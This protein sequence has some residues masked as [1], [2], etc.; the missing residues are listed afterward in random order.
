MQRMSNLATND[1]LS[2]NQECFCVVFSSFE[3]EIEIKFPDIV[4][5]TVS[6]HLRFLSAPIS[7]LMEM[8]R[9]I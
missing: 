4:D 7:A 9:E 1:C 8:C 5:N 2:S 6:A 3:L